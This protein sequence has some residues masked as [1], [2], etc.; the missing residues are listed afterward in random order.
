MEEG[1]RVSESVSRAIFSSAYCAGEREANPDENQRHAP[2]SNDVENGRHEY[3]TRSCSLT[4]LPSRAGRRGRPVPGCGGSARNHPRDPDDDAGNAYDESVGPHEH[5][6]CDF[7]RRASNSI[8]LPMSRPI[9]MIESNI[10]PSTCSS[11]LSSSRGACP[12][13]LHRDN[14]D[15]SMARLP[16]PCASACSDA[17]RR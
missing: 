8:K 5:P 16:G 1:H 2:P 6:R 9:S 10:R 15:L 14:R 3:V 11:S 12:F 13:D 7:S 17:L 4:A